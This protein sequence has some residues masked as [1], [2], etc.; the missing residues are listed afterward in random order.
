MRLG[1]LRINKTILRINKTNHLCT[2]QWIL[3]QQDCP[4]RS[5]GLKA[6]NEIQAILKASA[7]TNVLSTKECNQVL[8]EM[9]SIEMHDPMYSIASVILCENASIRK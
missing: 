2:F 1:R 4:R 7:R 9:A 5:K 8:D 3:T 6:D